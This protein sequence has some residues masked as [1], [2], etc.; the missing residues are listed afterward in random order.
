MMWSLRGR[1]WLM[2]SFVFFRISEKISESASSRTWKTND[3]NASHLFINECVYSQ[4]TLTTSKQHYERYAC[5]YRD[6]LKKAR[7][8][9][10]LWEIQ[11][12]ITAE[13]RLNRSTKL[14]VDPYHLRFRPFACTPAH[15]DR[16]QW[17]ASSS[18][19]NLYCD[20]VNICKYRWIQSF[21]N[22]HQVMQIHR[23]CAES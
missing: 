18:G 2:R 13:Q 4:Q 9:K 17:Q 23:D 8:H 5:T 22:C 11:Q 3:V 14:V 10:H 1:N 12:E 15:H 16:A 20:L 21:N 6:F 19:N 7:R